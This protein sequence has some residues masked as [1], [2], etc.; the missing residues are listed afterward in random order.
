M[1]RFRLLAITLGSS[2]T[3]LAA[4]PAGAA[5]SARNRPT[6]HATAADLFHMADLFAGQGKP[7]EARSILGLLA[8]NPTVDIRSE[9]RFR[10]A[11]LLAAQGQFA[12]AAVELRRLLDEKPG[13]AAARLELAA[14]LDRMGDKEGAL[15]H[16]RA[17]QASRLPPEVTRLVDRYSNALRAARPIGASFEVAIA[18]DT[19]IG[20]STS[21]DT[22][23]TVLGDFA[24]DEG[25]KAKSG[26]GLS[27]R[28]QAFRRLP[29][30]SNARLLLRAA[31]SA[32]LYAKPRFNDVALDFAAGPEL[33]VGRNRI[34]VELGATQRWFGQKPHV[35][36][37]RIAAALTRPL[38]RRSQMRAAA[39]VSR[40]D[41]RLNDLQD[42]MAVSATAGLE[43]ALSATTGVA[44]S[45]SA[46][47]LSA[48][49]PAYSTTGWRA[50]AFAWRDVGRATLT[51]GAEYG[52]LQADERLAL[53][54]E[55]RSDRLTRLTLGAA[56]RQLGFAG[57]APVTRLVIER[58][59][60][61]VAFHEYS[62]TRTELGLVRAF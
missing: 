59:R 31:G 30:G 18:P 36:S 17:L 26:I 61:N 7:D 5:D 20:R 23:G 4:S 48:R 29:V 16:M 38:G 49:D 19:N 14:L 12:G 28:G 6:V 37:V 54:P 9:A 62:R 15:R 21:S 11:Q 24:I 46:D 25:S 43:H 10:L 60:S 40:I 42:G 2:A 57:F 55:E 44:A 56:F 35:R 33:D 51:L 50:G 13:A 45:L 1:Q 47:R 32:D 41:N 58:N 3:I 27:V 22:L 52:R 39:S 53:L 34:G 8:R